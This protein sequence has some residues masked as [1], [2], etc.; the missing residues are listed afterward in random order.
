MIDLDFAAPGAAETLALEGPGRGRINFY[1]ASEVNGV[2]RE[3]LSS[4]MTSLAGA[5]AENAEAL[6]SL[7]LD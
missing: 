5:L 2:G 1:I 7:G 3:A 6:E 4:S